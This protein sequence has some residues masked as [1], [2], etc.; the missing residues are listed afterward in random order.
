MPGGS[1]KEISRKV[2]FCCG[3]SFCPARPRL[4]GLSGGRQGAGAGGRGERADGA[5]AVERATAEWGE[6]CAEG[7]G[8]GGGGGRSE[9]KALECRAASGGAHE[10]SAGIDQA[11]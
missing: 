5:D 1:C 4:F 3:L 6:R 7:T 10:G 2:D 8:G 11:G 9:H